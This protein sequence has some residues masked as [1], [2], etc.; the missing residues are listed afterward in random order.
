[1]SLAGDFD[2]KAARD[3]P[4]ALVRDRCREPHEA[5]V[6]PPKFAPRKVA[7]REHPG[8]RIGAPG[9]GPASGP[10]SPPPAARPRQC[11]PGV[12]RTPG[13]LL[14]RQPLY[15]AELQ[16]LDDMLVVLRQPG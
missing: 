5:N 2:L 6:T 1:M 12:T 4:L 9:G 13:P 10:G 15:P 16:G 14:R 11:A 7:A 8:Q 3:V